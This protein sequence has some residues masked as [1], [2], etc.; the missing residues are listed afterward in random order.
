MESK[1]TARG[2]AF[3]YITVFVAMLLCLSIV[4][5]MMSF[6]RLSFLHGAFGRGE[7]EEGRTGE[8]SLGVLRA[9]GEINTLN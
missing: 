2:S 7:P 1:D 5:D 3:G 6:K 8:A 9:V 4:V